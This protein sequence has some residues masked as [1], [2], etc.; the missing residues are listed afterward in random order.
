ML[1]V[2][3]EQTGSEI[4]WG[5]WAVQEISEVL[6]PYDHALHASIGLPLRD[7]LTT[8]QAKMVSLGA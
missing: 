7:R 2:V 5:K 1:L 8:S 6:E 3:F 4:S